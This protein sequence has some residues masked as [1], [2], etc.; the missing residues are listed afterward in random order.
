ML[1][2]H[3]GGFT[4]D[5]LISSILSSSFTVDPKKLK[6]LNMIGKGG[7]GTVYKAVWH[8]TVVAAKILPTIQPNKITT[9]EADA[10]RYVILIKGLQDYYYFIIIRISRHPNISMLLDVV[11][12]NEGTALITPLVRGT[13]LQQRIFSDSGDK[14]SH[15]I[16]VATG[17]AKLKLPSVH[18]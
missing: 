2:A 15:C 6:L 3:L 8:G 4:T 7:F 10:L 13:D 18:F 9:K 17:S 12:V 11:E 1:W 14:V 16:T 5:T